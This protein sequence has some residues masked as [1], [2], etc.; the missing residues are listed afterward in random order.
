MKTL[1]RV[2]RSIFLPYAP[3]RVERD[4]VE[5][6]KKH[7]QHSG[8]SDEGRPAILVETALSTPVSLFEKF[9]IAKTI[10]QKTDAAVVAILNAV[11]E[12]A[13]PVNR[14]GFCGGSYL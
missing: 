6:N 9:L 5:E 2:A 1:Y 7:W 8:G 14:P 4:F 13:S 12:Q 11:Y 3:S 10:E